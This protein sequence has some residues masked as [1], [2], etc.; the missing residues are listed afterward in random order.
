MSDWSDYVE[1]IIVSSK[2]ARTHE[3][4]CDKAAIIGIDGNCWTANAPK[5]LKVSQAEGAVI[6]KAFQTNKFDQLQSEGVRVEGVKYNFLRCEDDKVVIARNSGVTI[7]CQKT[8]T[9]VVIARTPDGKQPGD[10]NKAVGII[11]D[12][13][14]NSNF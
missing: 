7:T 10:T 1:S 6:G 14:S 3:E 9:A 2:N 8:N 13:L 4:C 12:H 5:G 11:C